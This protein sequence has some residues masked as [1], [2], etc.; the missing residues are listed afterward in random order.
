MLN[1]GSKSES[2]CRICGY[3]DGSIRWKLENDKLYPNYLICE[4]CEAESGYEDCLIG[5]IRKNRELW[6][7][8]GA[9]WKYAKSKP[10][11]WDLEKQLAQIP[12]KYK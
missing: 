3:D 4:C 10:D 1:N 6:L 2:I 7:N 12:E 9:Q 5:A 8:N 11:N